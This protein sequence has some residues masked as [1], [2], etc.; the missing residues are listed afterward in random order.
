M[1]NNIQKYNPKELATKAVMHALM[2][3]GIKVHLATTEMFAK[4]MSERRNDIEMQMSN[5][6]IRYIKNISSDL[7][8]WAKDLD[9]KKNLN[10]T[11]RIPDKINERVCELMGKKV[12]KYKIQSTSFQHIFDRHGINGE[13]N[14]EHSIPIRPEN[15]S[16]IPYILTAPDRV[17]KGSTDKFGNESV[18]FEKQLQNGYVLVV[19]K[20]NLKIQK[21][22]SP[23]TMETITMWAESSSNVMDVHQGCPPCITSETVVIGSNDIAKIIKDAENA[24]REDVKKQI[25][26]QIN[27]FYALN[28]DNTALAVDDMVDDLVIPCRKNGTLYGW[29]FNGNI[30]LTPE[31]INPETPVHE[32]T[33]L[34]SGAMMVQNPEQWES[35]KTLLMDSEEWGKVIED[36]LYTSISDDEDRV[37]S[38]T[39]A[40]LSGRNNQDLLVHYA[41]DTLNRHTS[42]DERGLLNR[43]LDATLT[44]LKQFWGWVGKNIFHIPELQSVR[45]ITDKVLGDLLQSTPLEQAESKHDLPQYSILKDMKNE[46]YN[47][48]K[49]Q[50]ID[51]DDPSI[52]EKN[53]FDKNIVTSP[54]VIKH[55]SGFGIRCKVDGQQQSAEELTPTEV[56]QYNRL[57]QSGNMDELKKYVSSLAEKHFGNKIEEQKYRG[58]KR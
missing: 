30:Y 34:W 29:T 35:I 37:A 10:L 51:L 28:G 18:R 20:E 52:L 14:N 53:P 40:R 47:S 56:Q 43:M 31:G 55:G 33:H 21:E 36:P 44:A 41:E 42:V 32:Y 12:S 45:Q 19:E 46:I 39:L 26:K 7:K 1:S 49:N 25:D 4:D 27:F 54:V 58:I 11:L 38:E 9:F 50:I 3:A 48:F 17:Y 16:L 13:A 23:I 57:L 5:K 22:N 24:I 2:K 8:K 6:Q 15:L